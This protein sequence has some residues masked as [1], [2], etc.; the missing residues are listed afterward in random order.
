MK[1][2]YD[3]NNPFDADEEDEDE[4][5]GYVITDESGREVEREDKKKKKKSYD[6]GKDEPVEASP[7]PKDEQTVMIDN[8]S[9]AGLSEGDALALKITGGES[10]SVYAGKEKAGD[11]KPAFVKKLLESRKEWYAQCFLFSASAP[12][13]VKIKFFQSPTDGAVKI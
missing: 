4:Y 8:A 7:I 2:H 9:V 5:A 1:R 13:M 10:A 6:D 12:V 11:L 3:E